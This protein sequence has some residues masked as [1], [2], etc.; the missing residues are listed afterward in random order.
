VRSVRTGC[1]WL[2]PTRWTGSRCERDPDIVAGPF[3]RSDPGYQL[4]AVAAIYDVDDEISHDRGIQWH[5][6]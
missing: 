2:I 5:S 4:S 3:C 1:R 6:A